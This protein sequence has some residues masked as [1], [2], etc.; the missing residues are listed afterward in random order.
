MTVY[1]VR[2]EKIGTVEIN[3]AE[4]GTGRPVLLLH[5]GAGP[6]SVAGLAKALSERDSMHVLT[7]THPGFGGTPRPDQLNSVPGLAEAY[8]RLLDQLDLKDVT[9]IGSSVGGWIAAELALLAGPRLGRL[10]LIDSGGIALDGYPAVDIFKLRPDELAKLSFHNPAAFAMNPATMT[11]HQ[12][13][14]MA[15]NRAAL[16]VY[17]GPASMNDPTLQG[18]LQKVDVPTLVLWGESDRV[19]VPEFGRAFAAAIPRAEFLL[20]P[21]AGHLPQIET[22]GPVLEAILSFE[23]KHPAAQGNRPK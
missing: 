4:T 18:R 2:G 11:D 12:K 23:R 21:N 7:P 8:F 15:A 13:A 20:L 17:S 22:P 5:G 6:Q 10:V 16:A 14:G 1:G 9:L 3:V 19:F